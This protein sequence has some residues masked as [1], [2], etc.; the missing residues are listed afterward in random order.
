LLMFA[1]LSV[2]APSLLQREI[3]RESEAVL[4]IQVV[5][6]HTLHGSAMAEVVRKR[7]HGG[8]ALERRRISLRKRRE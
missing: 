4:H 1:L 8:A 6:M 5:R 2:V 7:S 3:E